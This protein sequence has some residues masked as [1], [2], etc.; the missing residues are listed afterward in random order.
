MFLLLTNCAGGLCSFCQVDYCC[1]HQCLISYLSF[2]CGHLQ[3]LQGCRR[4]AGP[5]AYPPSR[6]LSAFFTAKTGFVGTVLST[7]SVLWASNMPKMRWRPG[8]RPDPRWRAHDAPSD[9]LIGWEGGT[10]L[11][12]Q[13]FSARSA[14]QFSRLLRSA[15]VAPNVK[16]WL[17]P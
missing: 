13:P 7:R 17:R 4:G 10:P 2:L 6:Q 14:P 11:Q 16:S 9:P 15:S 12:S 8:L 5:G 3:C 1:C